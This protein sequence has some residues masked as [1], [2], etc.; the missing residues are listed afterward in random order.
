MNY[1]RVHRYKLYNKIR[2][3]DHAPNYKEKVNMGGDNKALVD[4]HHTRSNLRKPVVY[5]K[6]FWRM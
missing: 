6:Y 1:S 3:P 5:S 2:E 4:L